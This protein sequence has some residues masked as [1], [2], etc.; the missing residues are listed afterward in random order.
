MPQIPRSLDD[1]HSIENL[2]ELARHRLPTPIFDF[3]DG[4]AET[5]TTARGNISAFDKVKLIPKC[6]VDVTSV[7]TS[8]RILNQDL[9]WPVFCAPTGISR[10]FHADGELAVARAAAAAGTM[11]SLSMNGTCSI[12]EV[13]TE[14][15]G[16]KMFQLYVFKDRDIVRELIKR[17]KQSKY[18]ALCLAVDVPVPGKRER[19]LRAGFGVPIKPSMGL[20]ASFARHP[21]WLLQQARRGRM[22]M[23]I[24]A[25]CSQ[26][27]SLVVQTKYIG[28]QLDPSVEWKDVREIIDLWGGPFALKGVMRADDA[29]RA[30]DIGAT[31]VIV[32]NHGGRQL[33]GEASPLE[34]LSEIVKAVGDQVEVILDGGIR[35]GVHVL[36]A[37]ALGAKACS[38]GRSYLYGLGAGGEK[39]VTKAFDI[40]RTELI[41]AMQLCGCT[42]M[43]K[44]DPSLVRTF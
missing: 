33:D 36:K 35:R 22:S 20:L 24:P 14:N 38:V 29:R 13:A 6:L 16:P 31:A 39:G 21:G 23:P 7:K 8:V 18:D 28:T 32:S 44:V 37:L 11:Y 3:L 9:A 2:Q 26:S 17:C 25:E 30:A 40:L 4:G 12:E 41:R 42:D 19:D 10:F 15:H 34:V 27:N 1:C 43:E 5:E